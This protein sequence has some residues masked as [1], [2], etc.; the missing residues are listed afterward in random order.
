MFGLFD[1]EVSKTNIIDFFILMDYCLLNI[2][3]W[4]FI[5]IM[6]AK[7]W[8][9]YQASINNVRI[10]LQHE[11]LLIKILINNPSSTPTY[12]INPF[13]TRICLLPSP[14]SNPTVPNLLLARTRASGYHWHSP[15]STP[16]P[17][18]LLLLL[19]RQ[20]GQVDQRAGAIEC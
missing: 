7:S 11:L 16:V 9:K 12:E 15:S 20:A 4:N 8:L 14:T 10:S 19:L 3:L 1:I 18:P 5:C 17:W 13:P 6:D 2:Y